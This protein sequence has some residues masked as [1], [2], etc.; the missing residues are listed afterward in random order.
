MQIPDGLRHMTHV[1]ARIYFN[2]S[3]GWTVFWLDTHALSV[4]IF[5]VW[6]NMELMCHE[7]KRNGTEGK[8]NRQYQ[9]TGWMI[10]V[11]IRHHQR[12]LFRLGLNEWLMSWIMICLFAEGLWP[13]TVW[14]RQGTSIIPPWP[15]SNIF[16]VKPTAKLERDSLSAYRE[17][18]RAHLPETE[19]ILGGR[20]NAFWQ[21]KIL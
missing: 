12:H 1:F 7:R 16:I 4:F 8:R 19:R 9:K 17:I 3:I 21:L 10:A 5:G 15:I 6:L 18:L 13:S 14:P 11:S 20:P 2:R